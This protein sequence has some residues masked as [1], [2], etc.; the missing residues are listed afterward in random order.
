MELLIFFLLPIAYVLVVTLCVLCLL[1]AIKRFKNE[2]TVKMNLS[3]YK[4]IEIHS[5]GEAENG[6]LS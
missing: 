1:Y 6:A 3:K 5:A 4:S 2:V